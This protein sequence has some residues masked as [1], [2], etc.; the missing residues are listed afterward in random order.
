MDYVS[1]ALFDGHQLLGLT[2]EGPFT[3]E[4]LAI[5]VDQGILGEQV[6]KAMMLIALSLVTLQSIR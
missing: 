3:R 1:D 4:E 5:E 6:V 2:V